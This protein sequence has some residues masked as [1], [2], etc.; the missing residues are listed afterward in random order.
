M[1][2]RAAGGRGFTLA[3]VDPRS[4]R[5]SP[6]DKAD[7]E[8]VMGELQARLGDLQEQLFAESKG[9][10]QRSVLL[11]LQGMDTSGKGGIMRHVVG[12]VDP[13]G[14]HITSFKAPSA[15]EKRPTSSGASARHCPRPGMIGVFDRSHYEDVLVVR[16][17]DLVPRTTWSRRYA[18]IN[19]FEQGVVDSGTVVVK[20]MLHISSDEQKARLAERLERE[21]KHWKFNPGDIDER[22]HWADYMQ[23]YQAVLEK[24]STRGGAVV[25]RARRPQVV[26]PPGRDQPAARAPRGDGPEVAGGRLRRRGGEGAA[27]AHALRPAPVHDRG[28]GY[29][30]GVAHPRITDIWGPTT[31]YGRGEPW[32]ARVDAHPGRRRPRGGRRP[33]GAVRLR[34]VHPTAAGSTS[35]SRTAGSS[36]SA[37]ASDDRVNHGRLGPKGLFGWQANARP[38]G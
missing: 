20:V 30:A 35:R 16:V 33:L 4:P 19:A 13:Q 10:G 5:R 1:D 24:C 37:G 28:P 12:A 25:R 23:A 32:P 38:T 27:G 7:G 14:V 11:V 6:G 2:R 34:A 31:P 26:R 8:E 3:D 21:D 17:H 36:A 22:G 18:Q 29:G 9:G 15:E